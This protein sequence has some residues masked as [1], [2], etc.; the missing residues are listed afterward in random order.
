MEGQICHKINFIEDNIP[1]DVKL[2]LIGHSIGCYMILNILPHISQYHI[3][4]C[5]MLFPTIE[6]M[7]K[8]PNGRIFT[9]ALNYFRWILVGMVKMMS[10]LGPKLHRRLVGAHFSVAA[11]P[12]CAVQASLNLFNPTCVNHCTFMAKIEMADV[13][14]L[15]E[16]LL[17]RYMDRMSF[18]Y[19]AAD[20][21]CPKEYCY[22]MKARFPRADIRLCDS[23][24]S[25]A[26]VLDAGRE[27]AH[28]VWDWLQGH[29]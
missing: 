3:L 28:V 5:F 20:K 21:W 14:E 13:G 25:H 22:N 12:E 8:T 11:V 7:A 1:P 4:R 19:G 26:F 16:D 15:Q 9:P 17:K 27:M 6:Q 23:D 18:Y 29:L 2:V 24:F 10:Y